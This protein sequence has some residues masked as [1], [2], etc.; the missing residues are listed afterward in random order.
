[1]VLDQWLIIIYYYNQWL[2]I[3]LT[4]QNFCDD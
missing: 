1:M 2:D 3:N 4:K